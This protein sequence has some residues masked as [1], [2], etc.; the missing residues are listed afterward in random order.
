[1]LHKELH[2]RLTLG[3]PFKMSCDYFANKCARVIVINRVFASVCS[4]SAIKISKYEQKRRWWPGEASGN[5][6]ATMQ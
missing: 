6:G 4:E 1:M 5:G 3:V 2:K